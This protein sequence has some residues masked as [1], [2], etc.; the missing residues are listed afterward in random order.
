MAALPITPAPM[1][2][3]QPPPLSEGARLVNVF[4]APSK[5]F[6][7]LRRNANWW[8]PFFLMIIVSIG[9]IFTVEQKVGFRR[10]TENQI[11]LSP[12]Q[13]QQLDQLSAAERERNIEIRAKITRYISYGFWAF[14][15]LWYAIVAGVLL[16]TFKLGAG[17]NDL[18][19]KATFAV[20]LY[21]ALPQ[22][23]KSTLAMVSLLAGLAPDS[24]NLQNPVGT[25]LGYF[26]NP[27]DSRFLYSF[28]SAIDVFMIWTLVLTAIGL[29]CVSK[30]K[31]STAM[32]GVFG[33]YLVV[34][35]VGAA[36]AA[37]S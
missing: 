30:L 1:P 27:A 6:S 15:L 24:F 21:S 18:T 7:D 11:Q 9:F 8:A 17:A 20:V 33:L 4:V 36:L 35:L 23:L 29:S 14:I 34:T 12:K 13:S 37:L 19:F 16:A 25:N 2:I 28:A 26:L 31:R 3:P 10:V 5:T 22:L 32:I